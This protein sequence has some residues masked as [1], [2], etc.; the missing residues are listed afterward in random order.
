VTAPDDGLY[1]GDPPAGYAPPQNGVPPYGPPPSG[2]PQYGPPG[3]AHPGY[4]QPGYAQPGYGP[5]SGWRPTNTMAILALV[6]IFVFAPASL[7]FGLVA[8][9][10]IRRTGEGGEGMALA[11]VIVGGLAT[12]LVVLGLVFWVI[13]LASISHGIR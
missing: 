1:R 6:A 4:A 10:Q 8:Q 9:G 7:V 12:A 13:A 3:Y 5:A 11:G 2:M